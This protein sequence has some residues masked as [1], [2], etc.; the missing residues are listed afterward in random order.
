M[1]VSV[2]CVSS[3]TLFQCHP[4]PDASWWLY[5][6]TLAE[7]SGPAWVTLVGVWL[8]LVGGCGGGEAKNGVQRAM[9]LL[10]LT[11][12]RSRHHSH[13]YLSLPCTSCHILRPPRSLLPPPAWPVSRVRSCHYSHDLPELRLRMVDGTQNH[14]RPKGRK[15]EA[16]RKY[17]LFIS[18]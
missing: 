2:P 12:P 13:R 9:I 17:L 6:E 16:R 11:A 3:T 8:A 7:R 4:R 1:C 5:E 10:S 15:E 14:R 18:Q